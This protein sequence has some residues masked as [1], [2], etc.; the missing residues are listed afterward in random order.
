MYAPQQAKFDPALSALLAVAK[1]VTPA[2]Q[3][4]V[5][6]QIANAAQQQQAPQGIE[7]ALTQAEQ[8]APSVA[9]NMQQQQMAQALQ[10]AQQGQQPP[11]MMAEG[12]IATLPID[13]GEYAEGGVIGY[14]GPDGSV[15]GD[16]LPEEETSTAGDWARG[17]SGS[18]AESLRKKAIAHDL[19][20]SLFNL[21][22]GLFEAMTPSERASRKSQASQMEAMWQAVRG[23]SAPSEKQVPPKGTREESAARLDLKPGSDPRVLIRQ[24]QA[25]LA[26]SSTSAQAR[27]AITNKIQELAAQIPPESA[28]RPP[29]PADVGIMAPREMPTS[30]PQI[31]RP[32]AAAA[33]G[34][35]AGL[36]P[37]LDQTE[38]QRLYDL[39]R[40]TF[41]NRPDFEGQ[42][43]AVL[44]EQHAQDIKGRPL[45]Q[46]IEFANATAQGGLGGIGRL[47]PQYAQARDA[48]D[49]AYREGMIALQEAKQAKAEGNIEKL[50]IAN[51]AMDDA[52]QKYDELTA[53]AG[54]SA[55]TS[56]GSQ[57]AT[58]VNRA[59]AERIAQMGGVEGSLLKSW[60]DNP[61]EFTDFMA[62]RAGLK[63]GRPAIIAG[64]IDDYNK[65]VADIGLRA[66][67]RKRGINT[68]A[69]Y[70]RFRDQLI[71]GK[72]EVSD[73]PPEVA[74]ALQKHGVR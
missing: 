59:S 4:T 36:V 33:S 9:Q 74:A 45:R 24:L 26:D 47:A 58:D 51:K 63:A 55:Y 61:Q 19:R 48:K 71:S 32:T 28:E 25:E 69:E 22:P 57:Y 5:A 53:Q 8:A 56:L 37:K 31:E 27:L 14:A 40:K 38:S 50:R 30:A 7:A 44:E 2:G 35:A 42:R 43:G 70:I 68:E 12:G 3:P 21:T 34:I 29:A 41:E 18:L 6:A 11:Q 1:Q 64:Y 73:M 17:I 10:Q 60:R 72:S 39:Q 15:V 49:A 66:E 13:I 20:S 54:T 65:A 67:L 46:I 23:S 62:A 52:K 16:E